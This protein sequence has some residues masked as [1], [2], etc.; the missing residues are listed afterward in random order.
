MNWRFPLPH[1][2]DGI[3]LG[4]GMFGVCVWGDGR[5]CLTINRAD[6]WDLR[7]H[8]PVTQKMR[9][10]EMRRVCQTQDADGMTQMVAPS[11]PPGGGSMIPSPSGLPMPRK[12]RKI[13]AVLDAL[14]STTSC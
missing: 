2:H 10:E 9:Y 5:L 3:L 6:F 11:I 13:S 14:F 12:L 4:N 7:N 8:R 1:T